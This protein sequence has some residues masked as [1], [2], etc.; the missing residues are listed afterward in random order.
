MRIGYPCI[1]LTLKNNNPSTFRIKS[2]SE[3]RFNETFKNNLNH[4]QKI[5]EFNVNNNILF[6]RLSSDI[7]PFA[8]HP[9][10]KVNWR[11]VFKKDLKN[12]GDYINNIKMRISMHQDQFVILNSKNERVIENSIRAQYHS[13]L[14]ESIDIPFDA[15]IQI[16]IGGI[17]HNK[18]F[19]KERSIKIFT[20]LDEN[21]KNRIVIEN[22][23]R[24]YTLKDCL[25]I[26][27]QTDPNYIRYISS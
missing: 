3:K 20:N 13:D 4:L 18:S 22:D 7:I 8:S 2:Y 6:F 15:K 26:N 9:I 19:A 12:I 16:H 25:E 10:C 24:L 21:L 23:D 5:L 11:N 27:K 17:Y 14:L 1:I